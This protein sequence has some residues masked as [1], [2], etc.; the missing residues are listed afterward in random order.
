MENNNLLV[1]FSGGETSAYLAKHIKESPKYKDFKK[2]FIFANTAQEN[3]ET[4]EFVEKIDKK[5]NLGVVWVEAKVPKEAYKGTK[6]NLVDFK[7]A[8]RNGEPFEDLIKKLGIPNRNTPHCTN[9]LKLAPINSYAKEFFNGEE[10][11]TAIGI[12]Y[13]EFDRMSVKAKEKRLIYPLVDMGVTKPMINVFWDKQSFRLDLKGYQGNC[14]TCWKKSFNKLYKIANENPEY[15]DFFKR[16]EATYNRHGH[17][18]KENKNAKGRNFF[19]DR[20]SSEDI[21]KVGKGFK[22][23]IFDDSEHYGVQMR[24]FDDNESCDIYSNCGD[25]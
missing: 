11:T 23:I 9:Y 24:L 17:E 2:L 8:S 1:S 21:L 13:D 10:Y 15:F 18:F 3:E 14:K 6:H 22:G 12:R 20:K 25:D 7:T 16:M 19:R 4:L 5:Y